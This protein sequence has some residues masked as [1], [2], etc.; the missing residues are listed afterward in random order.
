MNEV[1]GVALVSLSVRS[2]WPWLASLLLFCY[3]CSSDA[4]VTHNRRGVGAATAASSCLSTDLS[5][6]GLSMTAIFASNSCHLELLLNQP[7]KHWPKILSISWCR[8]IS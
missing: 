6:Y 4:V 7:S 8:L 1:A 5:R 2:S 3:S